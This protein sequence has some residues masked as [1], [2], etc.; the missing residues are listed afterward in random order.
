[1]LCRR[2]F[3]EREC[4]N[5]FIFCYFFGLLGL[6]LGSKIAIHALNMDYDEDDA[7]PVFMTG[8]SCIVICICINVIRLTHPFGYDKEHRYLVVGVWLLR[9]VCLVVMFGILFT[10]KS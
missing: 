7:I 8:I 10:W 2:R 1:M 6:G 3:G 4:T 5:G 9:F